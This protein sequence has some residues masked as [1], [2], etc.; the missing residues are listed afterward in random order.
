MQFYVIL[1]TI[2]TDMKP[3]YISAVLLFYT[4]FSFAQVEDPLVGLGQWRMHLPYNDGKFVSGGDELV[5]CSTKYALFS[6]KKSD[7]SIQRFSKLN[8][9]SDFEISTIRYSKENH[10]L[11]VAYQS[12]NIDLLYDDGTV[13]GMPDI[14]MKNIVGGKG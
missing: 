14:M 5:Y 9:L 13:I 7:G 1:G 6:Y 4:A 10:L 12:S 11:L 8:G 3:I 2:T